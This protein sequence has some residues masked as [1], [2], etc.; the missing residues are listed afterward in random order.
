[1]SDARADIL[2]RLRPALD[3]GAPLEARRVAARDRLA[4]PLRSL[5][6]ARVQN[7]DLVETFRTRAHEV[8]ATTARIATLAE[9]GETV[10]D[11]LRTRNLPQTAKASPELADWN[12][13]WPATLDITHGGASGDD[14]VGIAAARAGIA[15]T[16]TLMLASGAKS[17]TKLNF[18]PETHIVVLCA[19]RI[20]GTYEQAWDI[21]RKNLDGTLLPHP[22]L[23]RAVN[24]ITGPSR[25]A[26]IEQTLL[27]GVHGPKRIHIVIVDEE[28]ATP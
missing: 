10:A 6:P 24:W 22:L 18:L 14:L 3:A 1:M 5:A 13:A 25:T 7:V 17:P 9:L 11:Y 27:V 8:G 12:L 20:C 16:G 26:D 4:K 15:E 23:P 19:G 28:P 21:L 2:N